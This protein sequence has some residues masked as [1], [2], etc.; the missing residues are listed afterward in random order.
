M[1]LLAIK[2]HKERRKL[3]MKKTGLIAVVAAAALALSSCGVNAGLKKTAMEIGD[4]KVSTGD[5]AVIA[6]MMSSGDF[7]STKT[8][9]SEQI[10]LSFKYG[11]LGEALGIELT[12]DE[13]KS[14]IQIRAQ[15]AQQM[16]G[17]T[18]LK[19]YLADNGSS[20]EFLDKLFT[21]SMYQTQV[22]EKIQAD[23]E[24]KEVTDEEIVTYYNENYLC[25][26]HILIDKAE[27]AA[28]AEKLANELLERAKNGED[29]DAM[30]QE[31]STDPGL[32]TNPQGYVFTEGE[33]VAPFENGVKELEIGGF[34]ICESDYGYHVLL[35]L[36]LPELDEEMKS[37]VSSAYNNKRAEIRLDEMLE[38]NG[39]KV[40]VND[41]VITAITEDMLKKSVA[42]DETA[43]AE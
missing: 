15:Y 19:D 33:M 26:K 29:F 8:S 41:D 32:E 6:D 16:G 2:T 4:V 36:E 34:G 1:Y 37:T 5:V 43:T 18:V 17:L 14:A 38:D 39:I 11:E 12:D 24:G 21:A 42:D 10:E 23:L 20:V 22:N 35:R 40:V 9:M 13:K 25:A 27:D 28:A 30:A 3:T 31:Y 7:D